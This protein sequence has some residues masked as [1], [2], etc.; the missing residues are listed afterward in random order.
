MSLFKNQKSPFEIA[1]KAFLDSPS[2]E[3]YNK[4]LN[5][6][7]TAMD[8]GDIV[9]VPIIAEDDLPDGTPAVSF[10]KI[11][12][13]DDTYLYFFTSQKLTTTSQHQNFAELP[14]FNFVEFVKD[15]EGIK[16]VL[17]NP[18]DGSDVWAPIELLNRLYNAVIDHRNNVNR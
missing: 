4:Y 11:F 1:I 8:N 6:F 16:G 17:I 15:Y 3:T 7:A 10:A 13:G 12:S 9:Y 5:A 14:L 2:E 18:S